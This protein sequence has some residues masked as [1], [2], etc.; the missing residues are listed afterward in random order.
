MTV[1]IRAIGVRYGKD[2]RDNDWYREHC[3]EALAAARERGLAK[4]FSTEGS[5]ASSRAFD[6]QMRRY[7][8]D[9]FRGAVV[10]YKLA[11]DETSQTLELAAARDALQAASLSPQD[12]DVVL[13][14]S[15]LP[16]DFIAP[17]NAVYLARSLEIAAPAFNVE[18]ACSS[19]LAALELAEGLLAVGRYRRVLIVLSNTVSRQADD[20][21]TLSWISSDVAAAAVL[22]RAETPGILS[23]AMENTAAT[24]G[25][26]VH[27]MLPTADGAQVRMEI[28]PAGTKALRSTSGPDLLQRLCHRALDRAALTPAQ[29]RLFGSSTPLAWFASLAGDAMGIEPERMNDLF[30]RVGNAGLPFPLL[31]LYFAV[32]EGRVAP[33]D[34][35]LLY[36]VG[37]V[38]SAGAMV[39][40]AQPWALGPEPGR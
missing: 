24:A 38:S 7:T 27:R 1:S 5:D 19:G 9:P 22:E 14:A 17:G 39:V 16:E 31:H 10:R 15:W 32:A 12:V 28:G 3:P 36:T 8:E 6:D 34:P 35:I 2:R 30:P 23:S 37:S 20:H 26:F 4:A 33:D 18:S 40:R 21:N 29:I 11:A 25:V 13:C